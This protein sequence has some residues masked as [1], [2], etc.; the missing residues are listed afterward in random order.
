MY[1]RVYV[2]VVQ[3]ADKLQDAA[4]LKHAAWL[5]HVY[6]SR[7]EVKGLSFAAADQI[8]AKLIVHVRKCLWA[9]SCVDTY[10]LRRLFHLYIFALMIVSFSVRIL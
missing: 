7:P 4:R 5:S 9:S 3:D 1:L 8:K 6:D 2:C 10:A